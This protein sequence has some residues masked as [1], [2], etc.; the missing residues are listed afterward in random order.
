MSK[1]VY[2]V[3]K[4]ELPTQ[5][6]LQGRLQKCGYQDAFE[7]TLL[8]AERTPQGVYFDIFG[9]LPKIVE[10]LMALRNRIVKRL[11][12]A[13]SIENST[14]TLDDLQLGKGRGLHKVERVNQDEIICTSHD[15][16]MQ[17]SISVYKLRKGHFVLSTLVNTHTLLGYGYLLAVIP[18]HKVIAAASIRVM[19]KRLNK[20]K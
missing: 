17:V 16:H 2:K 12:F 11:G 5:S 7:F 8:D 3:T 20:A 14:L 1:R 10:V 13:T 9:H 4:T 18:F 15:R 6:A 19:L